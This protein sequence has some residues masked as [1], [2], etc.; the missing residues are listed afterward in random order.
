MKIAT[1]LLII[2]IAFFLTLACSEKPE[3]VTLNKTN[4]IDTINIGCLG[5]YDL[6]PL[7]T[8]ERINQVYDK[9]KIKHGH[10]ISFGVTVTKIADDKVIRT[11]LEEGYYRF[12]K[13]VGFWKFYNEDGSL[14][15]SIEYKND[16][17]VVN[18]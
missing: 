7:N 17:A 6:N 1:Q 15:D 9:Q 8:H 12:N 2:T 5:T 11:K 4:I 3:I 18:S 10:W 16:V 14:K 13:K